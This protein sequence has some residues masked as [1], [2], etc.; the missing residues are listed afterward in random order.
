MPYCLNCKK[1]TDHDLM[2]C[3]AFIG[4]VTPVVTKTVTSK[5]TG[6]KYIRLKAL[7]VTSPVTVNSPIT[8]TVHCP[9]CRCR[10]FTN[11]QKQ[12]AW[13]ERHQGMKA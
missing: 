1:M 4:D 5:V 10:K 12:K 9:G 11:A 6:H 7:P 3:K 2:G 8:E 13:R